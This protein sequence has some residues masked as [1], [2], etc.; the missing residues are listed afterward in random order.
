[1]TTEY[2]AVYRN[3]YVPPDHV[4]TA[5]TRAVAAWLWSNRKAEVA[6]L[7]A[8]ALHGSRWIDADE[9][10]ELYR[11]NS[12]PVAGMLIHRDELEDDEVCEVQRISA[13]TAA[14]TAFDLGRRKGLTSAVIRLDALA[15]ARGLKPT[16]VDGLIGRHTGV[17]CRVA[18]GDPNALDTHRSGVAETTDADCGA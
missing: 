10:A 17:R 8:A 14:R 4:L 13:T 5:R 9:P 15:N 1:L 2:K 18:S 3:V 11:R 12:K 16:D 6:G 7:S